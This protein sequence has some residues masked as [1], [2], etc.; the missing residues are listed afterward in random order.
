M[1]QHWQYSSF[2]LFLLSL[3]ADPELGRQDNAHVPAACVVDG[4]RGP[5]AAQNKDDFHK[6]IL[7]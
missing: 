4:A 3:L 1:T 7:K 2:F 5:Y 6:R